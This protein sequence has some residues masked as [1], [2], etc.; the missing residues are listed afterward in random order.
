MDAL[1]RSRSPERDFADQR[2][3]IG[4]VGVLRATEP[5]APARIETEEEVIEAQQAVKGRPA[6]RD[7]R[8]RKRGCSGP[9]RAV[10]EAEPRVQIAAEHQGLL[11]GQCAD[12]AAGL[13]RSSELATRNPQPPGADQVVE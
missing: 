7:V 12:E 6:I 5:R 13:P 10:T 8:L 11:I 3:V 2:E 9:I 1:R 4:P